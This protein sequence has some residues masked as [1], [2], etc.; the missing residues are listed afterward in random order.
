MPQK[1]EKYFNTGVNVPEL[2]QPDQQSN[3]EH[4]QPLTELPQSFTLTVLW[5]SDPTWAVPEPPAAQA[6]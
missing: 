6:S 2:L 5:F 4:V 1:P 3:T